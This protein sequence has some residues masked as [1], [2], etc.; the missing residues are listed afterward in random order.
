[1]GGEGLHPH[2]RMMVRML[3]WSSIAH[4]SPE[5]PLVL[6]KLTLVKRER[7][8][9]SAEITIHNR[10]IFRGPP[11]SSLRPPPILEE[12]THAFIMD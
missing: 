4:S 5:R 1:M 3:N 9:L 7:G 8:D 6:V 11:P 2:D 12:L 10:D